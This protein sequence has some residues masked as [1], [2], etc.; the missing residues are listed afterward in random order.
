M[1]HGGLKEA[2]S[3]HRRPRTGGLREGEDPE[4]GPGRCAQWLEC[5]IPGHWVV[6]LIPS[7][8]ACERQLLNVSLP[9]PLKKNQW[10][11]S[12]GEDEQ[13]TETGLPSN[14]RV[15]L[16]TSPELPPSAP[17]GGLGTPTL[18]PARASPSRRSGEQGTGGVQLQSRGCGCVCRAVFPGAS[19][20]V[21][22]AGPRFVAVPGVRGRGVLHWR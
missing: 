11:I 5:S 16:G 4:T 12:S 13:D 15:S 21:L 22:G 8:D 20:A 18:C 6:G 19:G 7:Q 9:L 17:G 10:K 2:V 1:G 14:M 3:M